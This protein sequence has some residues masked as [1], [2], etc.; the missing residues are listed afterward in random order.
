MNILKK[1]E[2]LLLLYIYYWNRN[3]NSSLAITRVKHVSSQIFLS[4][5][6]VQAIRQVVSL[7]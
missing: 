6:I 2:E 1:M 4:R 7:G 3:R 5:S